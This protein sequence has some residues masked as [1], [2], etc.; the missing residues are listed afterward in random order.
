MRKGLLG[1]AQRSTNCNIRPN[2]QWNFQRGP[3]DRHSQQHSF[4]HNQ[5]D[6]LAVGHEAIYDLLWHIR[7]GVFLTWLRFEEQRPIKAPN[8]IPLLHL[9][10]VESKWPSSKGTVKRIDPWLVSKDWYC[11]PKGGRKI[12]SE[13]AALGRRLW[14]V[15][16]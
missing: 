15:V 16:S 13:Q 5:N 2:G 9:Y 10:G 12:T 3:N 8:P 6:C 14:L 7:M 4:T 11:E 1:S